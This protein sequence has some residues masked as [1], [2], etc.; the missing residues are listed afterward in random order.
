[1]YSV[2]IH[3]LGVIVNVLQGAITTAGTGNLLLSVCAS[4]E[5]LNYKRASMCYSS[6]PDLMLK[7]REEL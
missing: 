1:M 5:S 2:V 3:Y 7:K 4:A 6:N